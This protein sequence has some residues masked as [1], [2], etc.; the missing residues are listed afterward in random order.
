[1]VLFVD[2]SGVLRIGLGILD[3]AWLGGA[4]YL[5]VEE[6]GIDQMTMAA[7]MPMSTAAPMATPT[8][9]HG[10]SLFD[11]DGGEQRHDHKGLTVDLRREEEREGPVR[12]GA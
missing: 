3:G 4:L 6:R 1:M 5:I 11:E 2:A 12:S 8:Q 10:N 7:M 9:S